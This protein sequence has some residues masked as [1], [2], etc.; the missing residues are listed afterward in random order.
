MMPKISHICLTFIVL[1]FSVLFA[2]ASEDTAVT[3]TGSIDFPELFEY[4]NQKNANLET[5]LRSISRSFNDNSVSVTQELLAAIMATLDKEVGGSYLPVEEQGDYGMGSG[6]TYKIKGSCRSTPYNGGVDYKGRGYIQITHKYN[7]QKYCP[8]CVG[9]SAPELDVCGCKN[10]WYCT[11]SDP[12]VC[13]QVLALQ[14]DYAAR[15]FASYYIEN[16]LVSLSNS[17]SYWNVG[18]AINGGDAYAS[19]FNAKANAYFTLFSNNPGKT[20]KLLTWLNSKT[21]ATAAIS[22]VYATEAQEDYFNY[23]DWGTYKSIEFSGV[24]YF[25]EYVDWGYL[26][27]ASIDKSLLAND[28]VSRI[29]MDDDEMYT[30]TFASPMRLKEGY[31]LAIQAVD[32]DSNNVR[33]Q[34]MKDGNVV[35]SAVVEPTKDCATIADKTYTYKKKLGDTEDI[36]V[37]AVHFRNALHD[38]ADLANVDGVWQISE[39]PSELKGIP[40]TAR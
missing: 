37:I 20:K 17:R 15:I 11:V 27:D 36:V 21:S 26:Y 14:P 34:L 38:D 24:E 1:L 6:C 8:D 33:V 12:A 31:E 3:Y 10:Q 4:S 18:K 39:K 5:A 7:Y 29:L 19:D 25:T 13:P 9:V 23:E 2:C 22:A 32:P 30:I 28:R 40:S 35:D 16:N